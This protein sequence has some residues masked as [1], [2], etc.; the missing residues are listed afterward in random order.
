MIVSI[1]LALIPCVIISLIIK[2]RE[3]QLKHM[4]VISGVSLPAYWIS[5]LVSDIVK[6]YVPIF[7]ILILTVAF[8]LEYDGVWELLIIY[9]AVIVPFTYITSFL[10]TG[11]TVAQI[12]TLFMHFLFGGIMPLVVFVLQNIPST[13]N[14]GDSMR[15]WF[16]FIP[17]YCVGHGIVWSS[18]W[19]LLNVSRNGLINLNNNKYGLSPINPDIYAFANLTGDYTIML[20]MGVFCTALLFII[21]ADIFQCCAKF[22]VYSNPEPRDDLDLDEDVIAEEERLAQ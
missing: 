5:N 13:A 22:S 3:K 1:A 12:M 21:E 2:E 19:E 4:Q 15:W 16:T 8:N 20:A 9:P 17:T 10:F 11:D 14:L 18:T 7:I 6:S